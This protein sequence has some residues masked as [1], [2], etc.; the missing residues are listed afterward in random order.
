MSLCMSDEFINSGRKEN[1]SVHFTYYVYMC[2]KSTIIRP[3]WLGGLMVLP[4]AGVSEIKLT[5]QYLDL[6]NTV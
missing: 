3:L 4:S 6:V 5:V 2:A 1:L